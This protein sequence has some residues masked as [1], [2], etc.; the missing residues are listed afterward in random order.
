MSFVLLI[1]LCLCSALFFLLLI[2]K[3]LDKL[4][5]V[6]QRVSSHL[7]S[8]FKNC[9]LLISHVICHHLVVLWVFLDVKVILVLTIGC[10]LCL[11]SGYKLQRL[12]VLGYCFLFGF[13]SEHSLD[14]LETRKLWFFRLNRIALFV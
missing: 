1:F 14:H 12:F 2:N 3:L 4:A 8:F 11:A 13:E 10:E 5:R 9:E 7:L 6:V